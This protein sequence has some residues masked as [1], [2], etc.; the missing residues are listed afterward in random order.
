MAFGYSLSSR[1]DA[2]IKSQ[3]I[4]YTCANKL[5]GKHDLIRLG[6]RLQGIWFLCRSCVVVIAIAMFS[7]QAS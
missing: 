4:L 6:L 1:A 3:Y 7:Y 5:D 2:L